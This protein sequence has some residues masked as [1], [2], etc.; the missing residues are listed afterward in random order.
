MKHFQV[1]YSIAG[2]A[3]SAFATAFTIL[4]IFGNVHYFLD[5]H[6]GTRY[7]PPLFGLLVGLAVLVAV[8]HPWKILP[9]FKQP[10]AKLAIFMFLLY[11]INMVRVADFMIGVDQDSIDNAV[12]IFQRSILF[13][14]AAF[15]L[16]VQRRR[17]IDGLLIMAV[18]IVPIPVILSFFNAELSPA[19]DALRAGGTFINANQA[20]EGVILW[21]I[22]VQNRVRGPLLMLLFGIAAVAVVVTFSRSGM[23]GLMLIGLIFVIRGSLPRISLVLPIVLVM[24]YSALLLVAED[25]LGGVV[26][27]TGSVESLME[28]LNFFGE[29]GSSSA[30]ADSSSESRMDI[31]KTVASAAMERPF[32]GNGLDAHFA[33]G[34]ASHNMLVDLWYTFGLPGIMLYC[35]FAWVLYDAGRRQGLGLLNPYLI[36]FL[37][38][39]P[40][41]MAHVTAMYWLVFYAYAANPDPMKLSR[42]KRSRSTRVRRHRRKR[43]ASSP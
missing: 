33:F 20:A 39:T 8:T 27:G 1:L 7:A 40:F 42:A 22:M 43:L 38:F 5:A 29:L 35:G 9:F 36:I 6:L 26:Q 31:L 24:S 15:I 41:N 2:M 34:L 23:M 21:L 18:V 3:I 16:F 12:N 28:R 13:P 4:V 25:F 10:I 19:F 14:C 37:W 32:L 11:G 17:F 30:L